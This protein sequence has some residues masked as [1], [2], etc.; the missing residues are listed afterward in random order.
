MNEE[1]N[2][3]LDL[4]RLRSET[5]E[6]SI[7]RAAGEPDTTELQKLLDMAQRLPL[8]K[9][10]KWVL[11]VVW[12]EAFFG[13]WDTP[14][15]RAI[16]NQRLD[17]VAALLRAGANPDGISTF[18]QESYTFR[19]RR[20]VSDIGL[21]TIRSVEMDPDEVG[22]PETQILPLAQNEL[23]LR[24]N[25]IAR[26]WCGPGDLHLDISPNGEALHS[27]ALA[28]RTTEAIL[29][30]L[31]EAGADTSFW[32][33]SEI[34]SELPASPLPPSALCLS[35]PL[36]QAISANNHDMLEVLLKRSFNPNARA[37]IAGCQAF[38]PMQHAIRTGNIGAYHR[39]HAHPLADASLLTP[40]YGIHILHLAVA[41][42]SVNILEA[43]NISLSESPVSALGHTLGH[44]ACMP[45]DKA[46]IQLFARKVRKSVHDI[47]SLNLSLRSPSRPWLDSELFAFKHYK[48]VLRT[49]EPDYQGPGDRDSF[50]VLRTS[51]SVKERRTDPPDYIFFD[52]PSDEF[53]EAQ[54]EVMK[55][56]VQE[57]DIEVILAKDY[58]GNTPM[59]YLASAR[60]VN[61]H[62]IAWL[63]DHAQGAHCWTEVKNAFGHT[64][65]D[66]WVDNVTVIEPGYP[67]G[68]AG[69]GW[70]WGGFRTRSNSSSRSDSEGDLT[71]GALPYHD[72]SDQNW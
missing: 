30:A 34:K 55:R 69:R 9:R 41:Q 37:L 44:I 3:P 1:I 50:G 33:G 16:S 39:L 35:T 62:L 10:T 38:T 67:S 57:L 20:V 71:E 15:L 63:R 24:K 54:A 36:N 49:S 21:R 72:F 40:G 58:M 43:V 13:Q 29:D 59:H 53:L 19:F 64:P 12:P 27:V 48:R 70:T 8:E 47:R 11:D 25:R 68:R 66:L 31:L 23:D 6:G 22:L 5:D 2:E 26:F 45:I 7:I 60:I 42:L 46:H 28:G 51:P 18:W 14:L 56:I 52:P 4:L 32:T 17:N 61:E 65:R